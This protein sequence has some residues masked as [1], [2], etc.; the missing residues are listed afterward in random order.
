M[1]VYSQWNK[2]KQKKTGESERDECCLVETRGYRQ[3]NDWHQKHNQTYRVMSNS[4]VHFQN[5][6]G[7]RYMKSCFVSI[8]YVRAYTLLFY[9]IFDAFICCSVV[10]PRWNNIQ[11]HKKNELCKYLG[12]LKRKQNLERGETQKCINLMG[13]STSHIRQQTRCSFYAIQ[14]KI[15]ENTHRKCV[16]YAQAHLAFKAYTFT[17]MPQSTR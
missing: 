5:R 16:W 1:D 8:G 7:M 11:K 10:G 4:Y 6:F 2:R 9:N 14:L 3:P 12:K 13:E 17:A 15:S